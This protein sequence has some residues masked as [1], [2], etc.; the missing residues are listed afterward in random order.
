MS[1]EAKRAMPRPKRG[2]GVRFSRKGGKKA[3]IGGRINRG[4]LVLGGV[5]LC[6]LIIRRGKRRRVIAGMKN[7]FL[8]LR[9]KTN[10]IA[11]VC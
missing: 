7:G 8:F 11:K 10:E 9:A 4:G 2:S 5:P 6:P 1:K 3:G